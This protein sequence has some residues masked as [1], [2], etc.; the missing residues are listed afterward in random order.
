MTAREHNNLLSIFFFIM[1]GLQ[2][3]GGILA[4]LIYGGMGTMMLTTGRDE[5]QAM[6]GIFIVAAIFVGIFVLL[7]AAFYGFT[8]WKL[9]NRDSIGRVLGIIGCFICLLSFPLGTALGVYGLW[10]LMGEKGKAFY[11]ENGAMG[12]APPPPPNSWQ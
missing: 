11:S 2:I 7:F 6:G 9:R 3:F 10:F 5:S 1:A 12:V 4:I 8:G